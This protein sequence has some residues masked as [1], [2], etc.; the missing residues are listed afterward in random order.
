DWGC[1]SGIAARA[2]LDHFPKA[3]I[4]EVR[5]WDRSDKAMDFAIRRARER[6]PGRNVG[7]GL[8]ED[9]ATI[10]LSHVLTELDPPQVEQLVDRVRT[11][12]AVIWV[13]PGTYEASLALI[14]VRERLRDSFRP[15]APCPHH[16]RCGIL[17]PGNEPHWCHQFADVPSSVFTDP[18]WGRFAHMLGIDLRSLPVAYLVLDRRTFPEPPSGTVRLLGRPQINKVESRFMTCSSRGVVEAHVP[19]RGFPEVW[20]ASKK[21]RLPSLQHWEFANGKPTRIVSADPSTESD[22]AA[23][24][25]PSAEP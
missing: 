22:G 14:A 12:T 10:L 4:P 20:Q 11:A 24:V 17:Q 16:G 21:D 13:E 9:P 1:G 25:E 23:P 7:S 2:F 8:L 5:F 18:F 6:F 19:R 15:V 3:V